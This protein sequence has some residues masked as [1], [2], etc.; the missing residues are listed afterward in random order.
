LTAYDL[1]ATPI[2]S[3][4]TIHTKKELTLAGLGW[5][6]LPEHLIKKALSNNLLCPINVQGIPVTS[7]FDLGF[8]RLS[9]EPM[10]PIAQKFWAMF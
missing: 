7:T 4:L 9:S 5:G 3:P 6:R 2:N 8:I 1:W 10:G